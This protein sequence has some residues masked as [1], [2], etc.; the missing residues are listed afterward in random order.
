M[1]SLPWQKVFQ[2][3]NI[4]NPY[5][6]IKLINYEFNTSDYKDRLFF[7]KAKKQGCPMSKCLLPNLKLL[8]Q[9]NTSIYCSKLA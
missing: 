6:T 5:N 1:H 8:S 7:T 9:N 2:H 4:H 3:R